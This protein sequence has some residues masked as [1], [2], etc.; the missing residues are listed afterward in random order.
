MTDVC[1]LSA[2]SETWLI[3]IEDRDRLPVDVDGMRHEHVAAERAAH[4]LGEDGLPVAGRAVQKHGLAGIDGRPELF[5]DRVADNQVRKA[6]AD[7]VA[8]D[9]RPGGF[10][11]R[12]MVST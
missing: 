10:A 12:R 1:S 5:E 6:V 2:S 8:I 3:G 4:A 7:V 9:V 11:A